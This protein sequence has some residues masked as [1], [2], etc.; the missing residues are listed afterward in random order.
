VAKRSRV[1]LR[2]HVSGNDSLLLHGNYRSSSGAGGASG[3]GGSLDDLPAESEVSTES[4]L[5]GTH[6]LHLSVVGISSSAEVALSGHSLVLE[7]SSSAHGSQSSGVSGASSV[8][9]SLGMVSF[10]SSDGSHSLGMSASLG[11][12]FPSSNGRHSL[13][14]SASLGVESSQVSA[15]LGS[16]SGLMGS[17]SLEVVSSLASE[18]SHAFSVSALLVGVHSTSVSGQFLAG[19]F[20][21]LGDPD[22]PSL[23]HRSRLANPVFAHVL[24][25]AFQEGSELSGLDTVVHVLHTFGVSTSGNLLVGV[26]SVGLSEIGGVGEASGEADE[27]LL[28]VVSRVAISLADTE[29]FLRAPS[30]GLELRSGSS[31]GLFGP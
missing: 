13:G 23:G 14:M 31:H 18:V 6:S 8:G 20:L 9:T 3:G 19:G 29:K 12:G 4:S 25:D 10:L 1:K 5:L 22:L 30:H 16:S 28:A 2:S 21:V 7:V 11:E 26:S 27:S 17:D 15:M 24:A